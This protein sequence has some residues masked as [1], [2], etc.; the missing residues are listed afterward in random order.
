MKCFIVTAIDFIK[1]FDR[2]SR[3]NLIKSLVYYQC[4]PRIIIDVF[5]SLYTGDE[6]EIRVNEEVVGV[7]KIKSVIK[8]DCTGSQAVLMIVNIIIKQIQKKWNWIRK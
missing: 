8:Q 7:V 4:D 6:T 1:T 2:V 5:S 3:V